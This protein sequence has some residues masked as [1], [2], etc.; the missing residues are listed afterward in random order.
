METVNRF[1]LILITCLTCIL[2]ACEEKK[3]ALLFLTRSS[4]NHTELWKE[5]IDTNKYTVYNHAKNVVTDPWFAQFRIRE[6]LPTAWETT[7]LAQQ[8]LLRAA[9]QDPRNVKFVFLSEACLPV[10]SA[11]HVYDVL[12]KDDLSYIQFGNIWWKGCKWRT[13]SEFP[14][15]HHRGSPQWIILN[16]RHAQIIAD[17][18][19]WILLANG[20]DIDNESYPPTF[21]SMM[22]VLNEVRRECKT[23]TDWRTEREHYASPY[24]FKASDVDDVKE[25]SQHWH[26]V[27]FAR[28]F[29]PEFPDDV[30]RALWTE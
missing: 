19:Y 20:H 1:L 23:Y 8:A 28:K 4:L 11:Q 25:L 14:E 18:N 16:R 7:M 3:V 22:G 6:T 2:E 13:L 12:T 9:L 5:W 10:K 21:L 24:L 30:I 29:D 17:D 26:H 15:E 27:L